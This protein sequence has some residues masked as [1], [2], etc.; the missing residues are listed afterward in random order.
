MSSSSI[1]SYL[2]SEN[3]IRA[4]IGL[5]L[6]ISIA[7]IL[8]LSHNALGRPVGGSWGGSA[9][10]T[11]SRASSSTTWSSSRTSSTVRTAPVSRPAYPT[12]VPSQPRTNYAAY[13]KQTVSPP[14]YPAPVVPPVSNYQSVTHQTTVIHND[15]R[16]TGSGMGAAFVGAAAGAIV[17]HALTDHP[18]Y[19]AAPSPYPSA[20]PAAYAAPVQAPVAA[21]VQ[22]APQVVY[23]PQP[24]EAHHSGSLLWFFM[25]LAAILA[26]GAFIV[27]RRLG[28]RVGGKASAHVVAKSPLRGIVRKALFKN[29][30]ELTPGVKVSLPPKFFTETSGHSFVVDNVN[31][32]STQ[33]NTLGKLDAYAYL[34]LGD[35]KDQD[36]VRLFASTD[37]GG[38]ITEAW[39]FS[40][41]S[42]QTGRNLSAVLASCQQMASL[43]VVPTFGG[44]AWNNALGDARTINEGIETLVD[45]D[46]KQTTRNVRE[47]LYTRL[48]DN[49]QIEYL[50]V[51]FLGWTDASGETHKVANLY[52]GAEV[53]PSVVS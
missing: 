43:P 13:P 31:P 37:E 15:N 45:S 35:T 19:A 53:P 14:R 6:C 32:G 10:S 33:V 49:G 28:Y 44:Y 29:N 42:A 8:L 3:G 47:Y 50:L 51:R 20:P 36:F 21:P 12:Y 38:P 30:P 23:V 48:T 34:Y 24:V 4:I 16:S 11:S 40:H 52:T 26:I 41:V 9:Y 1:K 39:V 22:T 25:F 18:A 5:A 7:I 46:N 17:G 27:S 2:K